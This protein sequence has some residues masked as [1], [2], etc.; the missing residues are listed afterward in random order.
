[1]PSLLAIKAAAVISAA[2]RRICI[3]IVVTGLI[4]GAAH[5]GIAQ[6]PEPES[7]LGELKQLS[8]EGM[9]NRAVVG[10]G[11]TLEGANAVYG[12][13]NIATLSAQQIPRDPA[14]CRQ[15]E[16]SAPSPSSIRHA[17][18]APVGIADTLHDR[19]AWHF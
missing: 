13:I 3:C 7:D 6:I 12:V 11:E 17:R 1:M 19:I 14:S 10:P 5:D 2:F 9:M 16:F 15:L 8:R 18:P 4:G